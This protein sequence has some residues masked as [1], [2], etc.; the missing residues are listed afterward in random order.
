MTSET[1]PSPVPT[2]LGI[3]DSGSFARWTFVAIAATLLPLMVLASFDFGVTWDEKSRHRYGEFIW[4]FYRGIRSRSAFTETGGHLY[5][6]LFDTICVGLEQ[7]LP[8]NR[9]V[10]RHAANAVFGWIGILYCGRLAARLFGIW[11][12]VLALVLL[13]ASPRYFADSMNNPKDVPFAAM[14]VMALYYISTISSRWPYVSWATAAKIS[15]SLALAMNIRVGALMYLGYFGLLVILFTLAERTTNWRRLA[16]TTVRLA[17][18]TL[19]VLLLG[20]LVWPWAQGAPLTRPFVALLGVSGFPWDGN[21]IFNGK[22]Y[23]ATGLPWYYAPWWLLISTPPV[24]LGGALLSAAFFTSRVDTLRRLALW[25]ITVLPI[26]LIILMDSTLYD[27]IRHLTFIY[28]I[29]VVLAAAGWTACLFDRSHLWLRRGATGLLAAGLISILAFDVRFHP[30][31][32]VYFNTLVSGP[33][34]AFGRYEMDYWGNC[35]L[36]AVRWSAER[37]RSLGMGIVI[38]GN[39]SQLVLLN[40]ERFREVGFDEPYRGRHSLHIRLAR[41]PVA[42]VRNLAAQPALYQV[43]TRD[44]VV[45]CNVIPGPAY[46]QLQAVQSRARPQANSDEVHQP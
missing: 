40:S 12:G 26:A 41:G 15:V 33:R 46:G 44:G 14:T 3:S 9:Y 6:G 2:D 18:V 17:A 43:K 1:P 10:I 28:P 22:D 4:E 45:L 35:V 38:S 23:A 34:G 19:A 39:P 11:S 7:W 30:N 20:T 42:G 8:G 16:G 13:A 27:G 29:L 37:A 36:E 25:S 21:V 24:V 31:Q 5:G 32:S